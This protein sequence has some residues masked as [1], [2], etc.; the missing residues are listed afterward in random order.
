M[1]LK[2]HIFLNVVWY[3]TEN[4]A[5]GGGGGEILPSHLYPVIAGKESTYSL[6]QLMINENNEFLN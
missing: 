3:E 1:V 4:D 5:G 6:N 2:D